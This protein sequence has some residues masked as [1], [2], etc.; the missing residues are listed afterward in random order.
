[1]GNTG[2]GGFLSTP[3]F[4][5]F[6]RG[7]TTKVI[8]VFRG[9]NV[10]QTASQLPPEIALNCLNVIVSA[11][12]GLEKFRLPQLLAD[13]T[14]LP[15][16]RGPESFWDFQYYAGGITPTRQVI[17]GFP[18]IAGNQPRLYVYTWNV[19]GTALTPTLIAEDPSFGGPWDMVEANNILFMANGQTMR[20]WLGSG[21]PALELW[22]IDAPPAAPQVGADTGGVIMIRTG[23]VVT[24]TFSTPIDMAV[25]DSFKITA[26]T[27]PSFNGIRQVLTVI[28]QN[29]YT[30]NDSGPD[31]PAAGEA[32]IYSQHVAYII[33]S[34][35]RVNG[36]ATVT[37]NTSSGTSTAYT[38]A[39]FTGNPLVT[40][41]GDSDPTFDGTWTVLSIDSTGTIFTI[42]MPG[43]PDSDSTG[44]NL[45]SA[46]SSSGAGWSWAYAYR[47]SVVQH[48]GNMSPQTPALS[49]QNRVFYMVATNPTD[50]QDDSI[51]WY[52]TQDGG[53]V[54]Y[55]DQITT[56]G[57]HGAGL[58]LVDFLLD[59]QLNVAIQGSLINNPPPVAKYIAL[60]QG[61]FFLANLA[62]APQD[63]CWSGYEQILNGGRPEM[64]F[65]SNNRIHLSIG[66]EEIAGEGALQS[67]MVFYSRN[68]NLWMLRGAVQD[69]TVNAPVQFSDYLQELPWT[70]GGFSHNSVQFTPYGLIWFAADKTVQLYNGTGEPT[71]ISPAV[72]P[73]LRS[74]TPGTEGQTVG[75]YFN[76]LDRDW[77]AL[78]ACTGG[79]VTT[80]T[81][82]FFSLNKQTQNID[83][84]P[85]N[86]QADFISAITTPSEQ[87]ILVIS[88][89]GKLYTL[90]VQSTTTSGINLAP[91]ST[92]GTL[93]ATWRS[94]Y[95]GN[96]EPYMSKIFR[97]G[98]LIV[99]NNQG[100]SYAATVYLV[101]DRTYTM[102]VP[103]IVPVALTTEIIEVNN[104]GNR[105]SIEINFPAVDMDLAVLQLSLSYIGTAD[106]RV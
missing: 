25:G 15:Y 106:R 5:R 58:V 90:P 24:G 84:F 41:V 80:N 76:W 54:L 91:T 47:N 30:W 18:A 40:L 95:F 9:M 1:M 99:D 36:V 62:G 7:Y 101:D 35:S 60:Y 96:D 78:L 64:S 8:D 10:F 65:P 38:L 3:A 94:G 72:Y 81:L 89:A 87:R 16:T 45:Y 42:P 34:A 4:N 44:G 14:D 104:R 68:G 23:G 22:G 19:G 29:H 57:P 93:A 75:V 74:I 56:L 66:A 21:N 13:S 102:K 46:L 28:D 63:I 50:P 88:Q 53:G 85:V 31:G 86:I 103:L 79:S 98:T 17:A 20:K 83:A 49:G 77:Y 27:I 11:S 97:Q 92:A 55:Q 33:G 61:R 6:R 67:G 32:I 70:M 12:G 2:S 37:I 59:V 48:I 39:P 100:P 71:D 52:R 69:I 73:L 26:A 82:V 43:L 105:C 51:V